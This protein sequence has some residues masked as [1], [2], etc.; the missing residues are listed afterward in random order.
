M[1]ATTFLIL[2]I[3]SKT[4]IIALSTNISSPKLFPAILIFGDSTVDTG[5][6][7]YLINAFFKG[8]HYP[9][10]KDFPGHVPTGRFSNGKLVPDFIASMLNIKD[11][12][13]PFLKPN[14]SDEELLTGVSFASAGAGYD[15]LTTVASGAISFSKQVDDYF[16]K[17]IER[18][19]GIVG[20]K[21]AKKIV[22]RALVL[23]SAGTND[24]GFNFYNTPT[25]RL[26]FDINGYQDFL[27]KNLKKYIEELYDLG[28]RKIVVSGLPP[29]GCLPIQM[30]VKFENPSDRKCL[31]D[32]NF[33]AQTYNYKLSKLLARLQALLP[34][35]KL[36]YADIY[37]PLIDMI[38][39]SQKYGFVETNR[40]CCGTGLLE[41]GLFCNSLTPPCNDVSKYLFWDI[42]HPS[43]AAYQFLSVHFEKEV[44][45]KLLQ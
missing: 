8:N 11:I 20:E 12:V 21:E 32:E 13:P 31:E 7:N 5:N 17:Y 42:A 35:S 33:D 25:R 28:C 34:G 26:E 39:H 38:N 45:P 36:V 19:Q 3:I 1:V 9:Y 2:T 44:L 30:T 43:E 18:I 24:F 4:C 22:K 40:G 29:I 37:G 10:G 41:A 14:L 16:K 15:D 6:N 27:Q 23:V